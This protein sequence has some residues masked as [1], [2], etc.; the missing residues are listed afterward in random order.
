M[1]W[2]E[3]LRRLDAD[4]ATGR[5]EPAVHRKERDEL[6][7][8][9][10]GSTVPSPVPSPL[11]RPAPTSWHSTNPAAPQQHEPPSAPPQRVESP[12]PAQYQP[13]QYR[14]QPPAPPAPPWQRTGAAPAGEKTA[15]PRA[16]PEFPDHL[17]TAP[18]PA[19]I[20]PTRYLQVE[21]QVPGASAVS[22][23]PPVTPAGGHPAHSQP[24]EPEE[25]PGKHRSDETTGRRRPAWLFVALGVLVV[26]GMVAGVTVWLGSRTDSAAPAPT[27]R[28]PQ[29]SAAGV[30]PEP[31]E[32]RLPTP[33]G[34]ANPNNSTMSIAKARDFG[35]FPAPTADL[36]TAN[37]AKEVVFRGSADGDVSYLTLVVPTG[38]PANAQTVVETLYQ[39]GLASGMRPVTAD[40]RTVSGRF[41]DKFLNTSWYGSGSNVVII[42]VGLPYRGQS[43]MS[44]QLDALVKQFESVLPAG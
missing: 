22:R 3:D 6:L 18:S 38:G 5:I 23:F 43:G 12:S 40:I 16:L 28:V 26:L 24:G 32:D 20:V 1:S 29:S 7:A 21:G 10:S 27:S 11:R 34:A 39:Q 37:G 15:A 9:A 8:Q 42:G 4:L 2:Q 30:R 19:D 44:G 25:A 36:F 41:Q 33:P 17:T 31:L 35:L 13:V 14:P